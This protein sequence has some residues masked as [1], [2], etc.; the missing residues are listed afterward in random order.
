MRHRRVLSGDY[1]R[2]FFITPH[3]DN[4]DSPHKIV[5]CSDAIYVKPSESS[6]NQVGLL[7]SNSQCYSKLVILAALILSRR[8]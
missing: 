6:K 8:F 4:L 2:N 1:K 5:S 3:F 7:V